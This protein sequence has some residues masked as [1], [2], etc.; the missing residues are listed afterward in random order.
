[1]ISGESDKKSRKAQWSVTFNNLSTFYANNFYV[2]HYIIIGV[3][4]G[5]IT[6]YNI[7]STNRLTL[8]TRCGGDGSNVQSTVKR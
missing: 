7:I 4:K 5:Q 1:M 3:I 6:D 2:Y 8:E